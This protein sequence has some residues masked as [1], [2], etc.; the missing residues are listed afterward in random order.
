VS[1]TLMPDT[2][3]ATPPLRITQENRRGWIR[4]GWGTPPLAKTCIYIEKRTFCG[5]LLLSLYCYIFQSQILYSVSV[6]TRTEA[7]LL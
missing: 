6:S 1:L 2:S 4:S 5:T 3:F 7:V